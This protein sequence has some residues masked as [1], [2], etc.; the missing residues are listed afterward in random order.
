MPIRSYSATSPDKKISVIGL[1]DDN[2]VP[3]SGAPYSKEDFNDGNYSAFTIDTPVEYWVIRHDNA[4]VEIR[5]NLRDG[6]TKELAQ[7][8]PESPVF[9]GPIP[10]KENKLWEL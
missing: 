6:L 4:Q 9:V 5:E 7:K 10:P 2:S 1:R 8:R 3:A